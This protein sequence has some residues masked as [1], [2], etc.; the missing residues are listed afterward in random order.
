MTLKKLFLAS[1]SALVLSAAG[2]LADGNTA[3]VDQTGNDNSL[4]VDQDGGSNNIAG[5]GSNAPRELRQTGNDNEM[6]V[7]QTGNQNEIAGYSPGGPSGYPDGAHQTGSFN[8]LTV[9]QDAAV[10]DHSSNGNQISSVRQTSDEAATSTTNVATITQTDGVYTPGPNTF[11][12]RTK[13]ILNLLNQ[14]HTGGAQNTATITQ[15]EAHASGFAG[16]LINEA[17]QEGSDNTMTINQ[18]GEGRITGSAEL[19][20]TSGGSGRRTGPANVVDIVSQTGD[21]HS[22]TV[23]QDGFQNY[24][25]TVQ[26][27][28]GDDNTAT[29][30]L[31][32]DLNGA[33]QST[34]ANGRPT[35]G[36]FGT[37]ASAS[38]A[39]AS[40]VTQNG[41]S[42][43][44]SYTV[45][46]GD[47]N[48]FG[49]HQ[50]GDDNSADNILITGS[51][52]ELGVYQDGEG[53]MLTLA[54]IGGSGNEIGL[55]QS[56][57]YNE[58]GLM[59]DGDN[60]GG[61]A[62]LAGV[63]DTLATSL[64]LTSGLM[65]QYGNDNSIDL[66]IYGDSNAFALRQGEELAPGDNNEISG[67]VTGSSNSVA[68]AQAGSS[69]TASF[70]QNGA[71][72]STSISQ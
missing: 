14:N 70:N 33:T 5:S 63:A 29:I 11:G 55:I 25:G 41:S 47:N 56:G 50:D 2:A 35:A 58:A 37:A 9:T 31:T 36:S 44:V 17:R 65:E 13:N 48:Q 62:T 46:G 10:S 68:V 8:K 12:P 67:T 21:G 30:S 7:T 27:L 60:N 49:F 43:I 39:T 24:V 72:N 40:D 38:G 42:N 15:T 57:D 6:S 71:G 69:N 4:L 19:S 61:A 64:G 34:A 22:A 3:T 32:G 23:E 59:I 52:N 53:N 66:D 26:Q 20:D 54:A 45:N 18:D 1:S 16:N 51:S 28:G